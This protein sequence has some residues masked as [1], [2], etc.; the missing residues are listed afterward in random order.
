[1]KRI[2]NLTLLLCAFSMTQMIG[3]IRTPAPSPFASY[4]QAIGLGEVTVEYSRPSK[5][6]RDIFGTDALVP[7]GKIWRTG[8][9]QISKITFTDDMMVEG[10]EIK[11]GSY[12]ILTK[13]DASKW[14]V[15]FYPYESGNWSSYVE[16]DPAVA[17]EVMTQKM[18]M[19]VETFTILFGNLKSDEATMS[20]M[21]DDTYVPIKL[22]TEVDSKVMAAID[23]TLAGPS[24]GDYYAAGTYYH[25]S[26]KDLNK[27]LKWVQ[28][29]TKTDNPR[30]WQVRRESLILADLGRY[31]EAIKAA[32]LSLELAT[33][34]GNEDYV[35]MNND[36]IAMWMKK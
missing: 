5:K 18:P 19:T 9:N 7:N 17:V 11:A 16:K 36:S 34:A 13:P 25:D 28:M 30:F 29:A 10:K 26:G 6:G 33:K 23:K 27:A 20:I 32:K 3:Q 8:A 2:L 21:W 22:E 35:K 15:H 31:T 24:A 14:A 1:M 4:T 12:G